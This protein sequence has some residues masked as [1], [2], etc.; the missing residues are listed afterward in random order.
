M[1]AKMGI[2]AFLGLYLLSFAGNSAAE[3]LAR[4]TVKPAELKSKP[5]TRP[6]P[7]R[8][9]RRVTRVELPRQKEGF[10]TYTSDINF[11]PGEF[12][13]FQMP[14]DQWAFAADSTS[15]G[16]LPASLLLIYR[17]EAGRPNGHEHQEIRVE[18]AWVL[19]QRRDR[20]MDD[21]VF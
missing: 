9:D 19:Q 1:E 4:P 7:Q 5:V 21:L 2:A 11:F 8:P 15:A 17:A 18:E 13:K 10:W 12:Y 6:S 3:A 20:R 14:H 16:G